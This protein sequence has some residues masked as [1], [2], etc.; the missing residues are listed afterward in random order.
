MNKLGVR[1]KFDY[2]R[3]VKPA[4]FCTAVRIAREIGAR[5]DTAHRVPIRCH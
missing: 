5:R 3:D 2:R 4:S 1:H